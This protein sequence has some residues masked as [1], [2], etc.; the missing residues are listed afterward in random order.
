MIY[1]LLYTLL[2]SR[3]D[4]ERVHRLTAR[5]LCALNRIAPLRRLLRALLAPR[6]PAL[7]VR[8]LGLDFP[9]PL[10]LAAGFDKEAAGFDAYA[11]LGFGCVEV[12][13]VTAQGQPGNPARA[14]SAS[15]ASARW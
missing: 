6:D 14:S 15:R 8:A 10:G 12:G 11:T 9:S 3:I 2:L 5:G 13:T 1:R 7:R 4:A